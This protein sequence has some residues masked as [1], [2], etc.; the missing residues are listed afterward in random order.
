MVGYTPIGTVS[1][2]VVFVALLGVGLLSGRLWPL[3]WLV[4]MALWVIGYVGFPH[5]SLGGTVYGPYLF[6]PY[7]A[8]LDIVLA[9]VVVMEDVRLK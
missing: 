3:K 4:F 7:V 6:A 5:V 8:L 1:A 2:N 9:G